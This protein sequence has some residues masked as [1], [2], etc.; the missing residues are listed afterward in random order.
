MLFY[1]T[2]IFACQ[3]AGELI[4]GIL[5]VPVPGPVAGMVI[6]LGV[7]GLLR[8]VP[9]DL[10]AIAQTLLGHLSL[11]FVP[12]AVGVMLHFRLIGGEWAAMSVA[13]LVSTLVGIAVTGAVMMVLGRRDA[14]SAPQSS[15]PGED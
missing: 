3:L 12:A 13:V 1:L 7:L 2:L 10:G 8:R 9:Q 11:L 14:P 15:R 4:V 6:M 5:A